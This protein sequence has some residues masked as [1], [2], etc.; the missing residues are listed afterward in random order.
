MTAID[1]PPGSAPEVCRQRIHHTPEGR[2]FGD[3]L[4]HAHARRPQQGDEMMAYLQ[5][6]PQGAATL[7]D[8]LPAPVMADAAQPAELTAREWSIAYLARKDGMGS[9]R[10]DTPLRRA[11][12]TIFGIAR[13]NPLS[14]GRLEALRRMAVLSWRHGYNV[15]SSDIR[16]FLAAGYSERQY[17]TLVGRIRAEGAAQRGKAAR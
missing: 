14:D 4:S 12:R 6:D 11:F 3:G 7:F 10:P 17:E 16:D 5:L 13:A 1:V 9:I 15:A 8:T 2:T